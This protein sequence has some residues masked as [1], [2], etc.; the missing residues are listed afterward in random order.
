MIQVYT[1]TVALP[2]DRDPQEVLTVLNTNLE[3]MVSRDAHLVKAEVEVQVYPAKL[4]FLKIWF[5][6][7]D[8]W[9]IQKK[10]KFPVVA[11]LRKVGLNLKDVRSTQVETPPDGRIQRTPR[12]PPPARWG[13]QDWYSEDTA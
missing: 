10:I 5:Q 4:V 7:S 9:Y 6:D 3:R 8:R 2:E 1:Y 11:A 12:K 13:P